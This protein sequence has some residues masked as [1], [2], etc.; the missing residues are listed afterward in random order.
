[1]T[2]SS[3]FRFGAAAFGAAV[4]LVAGGTAGAASKTETTAKATQ[5]AGSEGTW[6]KIKSWDTSGLYGGW[7]A[8]ALLDATAY[9]PA[10]EEVGEV[11]DLIIG[12]DGQIQSVVVEGGGFFDIGDSHAA[13]PWNE[14]ERVGT[15]SIRVP[16]TEDNLD[17]YRLFSDNG[18]VR[19]QPG[20]FR[21]E[22]MIGDYITANGVGYGSIRDVIFDD[23]GKIQSVVATPAY[24]YGYPRGPVALPYSPLAYDTY[25]A[26]YEM[27][28]GIASLEEL[29][30]FDYSRLE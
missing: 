23:Q 10:G 16:V 28:Y 3:R 6:V 12:K 13:I 19:P 27:P 8:E 4:L 29:K 24:G 18:N 15:T 21:V 5:G 30:P 17:R 14:V 25:G 11:E 22:E 26:Y 7:S 2:M 20:S 9:G 1:M